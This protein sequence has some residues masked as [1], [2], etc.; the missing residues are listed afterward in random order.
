MSRPLSPSFAARLLLF[1]LLAIVSAPAHVASADDDKQHGTTK[2]STWKPAD[3]PLMTRWAKDVS[4]ENAWPEYPRPQMVREKWQNLNGLWKYAITKRED[5]QPAEFEGDILVPYPIE[6][7]LSGVMR[8]LGYTQR[9]WYHRTFTV[10][11]DWRTNKQ[12]LLLHFGAVDWDTTVLVNGKEVGR[13]RGGYDPFTFDITDALKEGNV[14]QEIVVSVWDGTDTGYQC[15]GKQTLN[16]EGVWYTAN[17]GIWQTVWLEPVPALHIDSLNIVPDVD[18]G[19]VTVTVNG[20]GF[21]AYVSVLDG[22]RQV[23]L[24]TGKPNEPIEIPIKDA[25]LWS[26]ESP[27]LYNLLVQVGAKEPLP[28][29]DDKGRPRFRGHVDVVTSYFGMRKVSMKKDAAGQLRIYLN[30]KMLFQYGLLD[31]GY[32][33]DG[34]YAPPTDEAMRYDIEAT[35]E[36]GFNLIRKHV[37]IEPQRWYT[38][39]DRMGMLVWQDMPNGDRFLNVFRDV[40]DPDLI[41]SPESAAQFEQELAAMIKSRGNHPCILMWAPFNEGWG[42]YDTARISALTKKLDPSRLVD[43]ASGLVDRGTGDVNDLH[44]Y[45]GL[46]VP[47][48]EENRSVVL[49]EFGGLGRRVKGH[50]WKNE[51]EWDYRR[52]D[53][54]DDLTDAYVELTENLKV[55]YAR[56]MSGAV[57]TQTTDVEIEVNG[58]LTYD[59]ELFKLHKDKVRAANL[60]V[61][62]KPPIVNYLMPGSEHAPQTWR[63]SDKK[64]A[65]GWNQP[66]FSDRRWKVVAGVFGNGKHYGKQIRSEWTEG[67]IYLRRS[68]ELLRDVP[69]DVQLLVHHTGPLTVSINGQSWKLPNTSTAGYRLIPLPKT[70]RNALNPQKTNEIALFCEDHEGE[71]YLDV[72]LV[73]LSERP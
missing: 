27:F 21:C 68:F 38:Y 73:N 33:P 66:G 20:D 56:G 31:Q 1:A 25:K 46:S 16:P 8:R 41:R 48:P 58:H 4:P 65:D 28:G 22:D 36:L 6:S 47:L 64:P 23:K 19:L 50:M 7:A 52:L 59:R 39:C 54:I 49:G 24:G 11:E 26:P 69:D 12:R 3:G 37:K 45:L 72:G 63:R 17:S 10:P 34:I 62:G 9:L 44:A 35:R 13:H 70:L 57:Y 51:K 40:P 15:R 61:Y 18:R 2:A 30:D 5:S 53:N 43:S 71:H 32:W 14:E 42:Q 60:S 55:M 29:K 67:D